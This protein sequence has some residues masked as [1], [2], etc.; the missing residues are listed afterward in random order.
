[1]YSG[2]N[3]SL[4]EFVNLTE[5]EEVEVCVTVNDDEQPLQRDIL[6][7]FSVIPNSMLSCESK[8]DPV[9]FISN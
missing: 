7:S 4:P 3:I 5:G 2:A 1:M 6:L 8:C 9:S